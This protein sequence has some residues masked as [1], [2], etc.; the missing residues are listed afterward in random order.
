MATKTQQAP[1]SG[2]RLSRLGFG[3][4]LRPTSTAKPK[5]RDD[6]D[7]VIPY[8]GP[9]EVPKDHR[10]RDSWGD[11][12]TDYGKPPSRRAESTT[13]NT[14]NSRPE[15]SKTAN[16]RSKAAREL[17]KIDPT[18]TRRSTHATIAQTSTARSFINPD[19][20]GVGASPVNAQRGSPTISNRASLSR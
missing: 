15:S 19:F 12:I 4:G 14:Y 6:E 5:L 17:P 18:R 20:G 1:S 11:L 13:S 10:K 8:T 2:Q 9:Y 7:W 3:L 16:T